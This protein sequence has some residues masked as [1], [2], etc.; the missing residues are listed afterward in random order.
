QAAGY[1]TAAELTNG[2]L[3]AERGWRRGFD[4]FRNEED[5]SDLADILTRAD[6]VTRNALSWLRLNRREPFFLW[7]HYI[8]PHLPYDSPDTPEEVRERYSRG[9]P[10]TRNYW[11]ETMEGAPDDVRER[12]EEYCRAMYAEEVRYADRWV[13]QLLDRL[14]QMADFDS[15]LVVISTDHGEELFDHKGFEHGHSLY[16]EVLRVPLLIKW[17]A[18]CEADRE[19]TQTVGLASLAR[20]ALDIAGVPVGEGEGAPALPRRGGGPGMEV[21]SEGLL[22]GVDMSSLTTDD[23][24]VIYHPFRQPERGRFE[25]YDRRRDRS[26]QHDLS[27]SQEALDLRDRLVEHTRASDAAAR[28]WRG[29]GRLELEGTGFSEE[30]RER[31]KALGYIGG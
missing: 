12:Y 9:Y 14:R 22:W 27:D 5:N 17:P 2:F 6:N 31:L 8:D 1:T 20:T 11:Y 3:S 26:E 15:M 18:G 23:Y 19:V 21:Y 7:V 10:D 29:S 28:E 4:Y 13:G 16:E 30:N 25:V 24:K